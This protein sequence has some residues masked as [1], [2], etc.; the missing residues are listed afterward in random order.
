[1][2]ANEIFANLKQ[3]D[4]KL[5][6]QQPV[7]LVHSGSRQ[8]IYACLF[9][10]AHHT[11]AT[12]YRHAVHVAEFL[13]YHNAGRCIAEE[14]ELLSQLHDVLVMF[15]TEFGDCDHGVGMCVCE[16]KRCI[17]WAEALC[18]GKLP[19]GDV[20]CLA[21]HMRQCISA[22]LVEVLG[23]LDDADLAHDYLAEA[24]VARRAAKYLGS[25]YLDRENINVK[26]LEV[27]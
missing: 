23:W 2:N 16:T 4:P 18:A 26:F 24:D 9:C 21:Y 25:A 19:R 14:H 1:M 6:R 22:A 15:L 20:R 27:A 3:C 11:A 12:S 7:G 10:G 17:D 8:T 13:R 5:R